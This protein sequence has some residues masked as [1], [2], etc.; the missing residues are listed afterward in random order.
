MG[1]LRM[2]AQLLV[3]AMTKFCI[4]YV[5]LVVWKPGDS[6]MV[7]W[8]VVK[9]GLCLVCGVPRSWLRRAHL[10]HCKS[11]ACTFDTLVSSTAFSKPVL[12]HLQKDQ[13]VLYDMQKVFAVDA[14]ASSHPLSRHEDEVNSPAQISEMFNT[15]SYSKVCTSVV[16]AAR[17]FIKR[18]LNTLQIWTHIYT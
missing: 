15:I 12:P 14:L 8:L 2:L 7:E 11:Y 17:L 10:E 18:C 16:N 3:V 13:I 6:A 9:W 4:P 1:T 5:F